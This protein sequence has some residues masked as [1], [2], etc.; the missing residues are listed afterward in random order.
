MSTD[1]K[2]GDGR[3]SAQLVFQAEV[4]WNPKPVA[5]S[6]LGREPRGKGDRETEEREESQ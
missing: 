3:C 6:Q 5:G 1:I 4:A 2:E